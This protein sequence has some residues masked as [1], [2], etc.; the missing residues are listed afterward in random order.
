[1]ETV[2]A[3]GLL[4]RC[5]TAFLQEA[6]GCRHALLL[7]EGPGRFLVALLR[8]HP[9]IR[10]TCVEGSAAMVNQASQSLRRQ[11]LDGARVQFIVGDALVWEAPP[12]RFDLVAT[13]FFLD[14]FQ[15]A[16]LDHLVRRLGTAA[17][18][19]ARWLLADFRL[20]DRGLPR[21]RARLVLRLMYAFFGAACRL[22]AR[23]LTPPDAYLRAAGFRLRERRLANHGFIHSDLWAREG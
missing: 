14:C 18:A 15:P 7:G 10:I 12:A 16:Q 5:R 17:A 20:P 6:T 23:Q 11:G 3:G 13:Y 1:M 9:T 4:Q 19:N 22:P 21:W 2:L 8:A